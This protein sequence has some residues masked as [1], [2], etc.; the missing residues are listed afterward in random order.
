MITVIGSIN[1][2]LT[3]RVP[4]FSIRN[5][6]VV[7]TGDYTISQGGKG[8]NQAVTAA[9]TGTPVFM[10]GKIG[11]DDFGDRALESLREAGVNC[12]HVTRTADHATGLATIL[13]D[14]R[15]DNSITVAPGANAC[16]SPEDIRAARA[17]IAESHFILLQLEIP[18]PAVYE[19]IHI[20][21]ETGTQVILDPAPAPHAPLDGLEHVDYLTPNELEAEAMTGLSSQEEGGPEAIVDYLLKLGVKNVALTL[22]ARGSLIANASGRHV[23]PAHRVTAVDSTGAGD[24]F[25]GFLA[26]ALIKGQSFEDA[27]KTASAAAALS[28]TRPQARANLPTWDEVNA[29]LNAAD[30]LSNA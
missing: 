1:T 7:G 10:V 3:I 14:D 26:T 11:Q 29:F 15:G 27:A 8:A 19:A 6:T 4:R 16:L 23:I 12:R 2:D 25:T 28:V 21:K 13:V 18:L 9:A 24:V 5:E 17:L 20:A 30:P 22:G